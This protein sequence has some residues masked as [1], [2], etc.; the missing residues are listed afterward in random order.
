MPPQTRTWDK[1]V[2]KKMTEDTTHAIRML[3]QN[4]NDF[5][6]KVNII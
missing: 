1:D 2:Y 5:T 3:L 6:R 4:E